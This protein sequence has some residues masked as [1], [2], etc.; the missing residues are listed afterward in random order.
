MTF[1]VSQDAAGGST[2]SGG[3]K[4]G[5]AV[6]GSGDPSSPLLWLAAALALAGARRRARASRRL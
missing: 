4:S 1:T 5:C 2:A 3:G 6:T